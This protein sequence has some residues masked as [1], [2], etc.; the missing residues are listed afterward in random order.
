MGNGIGEGGSGFLYGNALREKGKR[1]C[2]V[3]CCL[4]CVAERRSFTTAT[5][6]LPS[7]P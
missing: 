2:G 4:V 5:I 3:L 6:S 1:R 7:A